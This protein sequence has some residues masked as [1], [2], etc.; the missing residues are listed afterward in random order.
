MPQGYMTTSGYSHVPVQ[1]QAGHVSN[2]PST[3]CRAPIVPY[4][5]YRFE[6]L[7]HSFSMAIIHMSTVP[8]LVV[9]AAWLV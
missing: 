8:C 9:D 4:Y 6:Y 2:P 3:S 7:I 1:I 5:R